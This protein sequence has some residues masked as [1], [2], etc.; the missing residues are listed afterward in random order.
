MDTRSA[1]LGRR[2]WHHTRRLVWPLLRQ[3]LGWMFILLGLV[4]LVLPLLQGVL[5]L[6]IGVILVGRRNWLIRRTTVGLKRG[7]RRWARHHH[8]I[9]ARPGRMALRAQHECSRQSRRLHRRFAQR[10]Q[11]QVDRSIQ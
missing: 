1:Q 9:V 10:A 11:R 5:F 3:T 8:H 7:L 2:A 4:G 6:V